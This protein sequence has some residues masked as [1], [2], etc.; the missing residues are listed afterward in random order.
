MKH[1]TQDL[2]NL[3][4]ISVRHVRRQGEPSLNSKGHCVYRG[5][6]GLQCAAGP[7]I[8]CYTRAMDRADINFHALA[9]KYPN[10]ILPSARRN[11]HFVSNVL[12]PA[13]D[14][15]TRDARQDFMTEYHLG[16]A[17]R[18]RS[19]KDITGIQLS[20]PPPIAMGARTY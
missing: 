14:M 4:N 19:Y 16:L 7:F 13:H 1:N 11:E 2:Q 20:I 12:Q 10:R 15:A 18:L 5:P 8:R 9:E 6:G 3:L 17:Q